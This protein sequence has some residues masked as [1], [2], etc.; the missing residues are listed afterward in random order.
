MTAHQVEAETVD[1]ELLYPILDRLQHE[2]THHGLLRGSLVATPRT[3]G[4]LS[5][6]RLAIV[7]VGIG[8]LEIGVLDVVGMVIH[9]VEDDGNAS[10]VQGLHHLLELLDTD[11]GVIGV[12]GVASLRHVIVHGVVTPV[13][14]VVAQTGL[15][16]R[17]VVVAGQDMH[18][19][20]T[21]RL[22]VIEG[23][24]LREHQELARILGI[25][26]SNG[27]VAVMQLI[28]HQ[29]GRRLHDR[30][31]VAAPVVRKRLRRIDN[32]CT[33]TIDTHRLGKDTGAF[34]TTHV[35]GVEAS[36]KVTLHH[37]RPQPV[38]IG[39]L[40]GLQRLASYTV[41]ID[42]Y[43]HLL[44]RSGGKEVERGLMGSILHL[45]KVEIG[46]LCTGHCSRHD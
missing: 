30:T 5:V 23:P 32:G 34:A 37:S 42:S 9:H 27:K 40:D 44:R 25:G 41:L 8:S 20:D 18:G 28:D 29:V 10:L 36:H 22:Q 2:A 3:V 35:E 31:L 15:V 6:G 12:S 1:T 39:H 4:I 19:I 33:L 11:N 38:G 43:Y 17:T 7:I 16:H 46:S 24:R 21:Q 14:L 45:G 26:T 13:V